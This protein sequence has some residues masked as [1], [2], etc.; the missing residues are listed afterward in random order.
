ML[1]GII[2][3]HHIGYI[4]IPGFSTGSSVK[5]WERDIDAVL[6]QLHNT[7]GIIVDLRVNPGGVL[8]ISRAVMARF[9]DTTHVYGYEQFRKRPARS[10]FTP[11]F[12]LQTGPAGERQYTNPI[13]LLV[14]K[15]TASAAEDFVLALRQRPHVTVVGSPTA[16]ALGLP[17]KGQLPNGWTYQLTVSKVFTVDMISYEGIG[18]PPDIAVS[19][20]D[21]SDTGDPVLEKGIQV[22][23]GKF[24]KKG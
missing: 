3:G 9:M 23:E 6:E 12:E 24:D 22:L 14:G 20:S 16:G 1:Y 15:N 18:I 10:D 13:V 17:K 11:L 4:L 8:Q 7:P 5:S 21:P 2:R 19:F